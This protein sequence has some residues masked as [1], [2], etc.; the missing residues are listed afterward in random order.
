VKMRWTADKLL[1]RAADMDDLARRRLAAAADA[2]LPGG[3]RYAA[4][5]QAQ[6]CRELAEGFREL[7]G[8]RDA[9]AK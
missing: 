3:M 2:K 7:A 1:K 5:V 6:D 9:R 4:A 8:Q